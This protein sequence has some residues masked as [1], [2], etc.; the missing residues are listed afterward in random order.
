MPEHDLIAPHLRDPGYSYRA[1]VVKV[2]DAD[3][4]DVDIDVGFNILVRKRLRLYG[5]NAW[6]TRG[7]ERNLGLE[8][9]NY[10]VSMIARAET[11]IVQTL[12]DAEGKYGRLL[13]WV[14]VIPAEKW[15]LDGC[16]RPVCLNTELI[17]L[18]HGR[19]YMVG[20]T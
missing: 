12:M 3:T 18:G 15:V 20:K 4:I 13:A 9:K 5:V 2:V 10:V 7:S 11:V 16:Y 6:E 1:H 17:A 19:P 14:F 8:A